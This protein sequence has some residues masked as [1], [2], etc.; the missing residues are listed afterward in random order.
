M[1]RVI[2]LIVGG[3]KWTKSSTL[4]CLILI[5][6]SFNINAESITSDKSMYV[7]SGVVTDANTQEPLAGVNIQIKGE[8][9]GTST[10][11]EGAFSIDVEEDDI[12]IF[13][14]VGFKTVE[15]PVAG[16]TSM[17]VELEEDSQLLDELIVVGYGLQRRESVTGSIASLG[18]DKIEQIPTASFETA[19]QGNVAGVQLISADGAPGANTQI[20]IRGIGS[21]SASSSPLYVV[22]GVIVTSGSLANLNSNGGRS[23]NVMATLNP[24]D[25][26]SVSIL[27]DAAS[28][29][30]YGSRGAN[31]VVLITT[32]SGRS[33]APRVSFKSQLGFNKV[34][35]NSLL[36]PL[37]A[38]EYTTLFLEGYTNRGETSQEAQTRFDNRFEQ[39]TDPQTGLPTDTDWLEE[40]TRTGRNQSYD[41]SVSG[42]SEG[43]RYFVSTN[44]FDQESHIIGTDF[45]RIATRANLD[46]K[47]NNRFDIANKLQLSKTDQ[48]GMVDGSAWANPIYN[49]LL[50]SPLIPIKDE[51][52]LFNSE[53]KNYF[54]MGGNNPVG[55]LS[56]DDLRKIGQFRLN[57][58]LSGR[59]RLLDNLVLDSKVNLD[60]IKVSESS[61]KNPRYGDGRNVGGYAQE[62]EISRESFTGTQTINYIANFDELH[63]IETFIGFEAQKSETKSFTGYGQNFPNLKLT[64]LSSAAE[65]YEASSTLTEFSFASIFAR[66]IYDYDDK[67]FLQ[68][69]IRRDGSSRF[70]S[71]NRWGTFFSVGLGWSLH[72]EEF[73]SD[74]EFIDALKLRSSFGTTGNAEIGN[75]PS[76]GLY[77][78]GRDYDGEPGGV[79]VQIG[80]P[81]LT[82]ERQENFN[83]ALEFGALE[84]I[85]GTIEYFTRNSTDLL[86]DVPISRTTGFADVT[87]NAGSL[88]NKGFE[89]ALNFNIIR[90]QDLTWDIGFNT[91]FI[92]NEVTE[93]NEPYNDGTKRREVGRDYQSYYLYDWAGVD[94]SNGDPLWYTDETRSTTTNDINNAERFFVGKSA[95]PDHYGGFNTA[96]FFKNFSFDAQFSYSWGNYIYGSQ[97]RFIHAD[98]ALTP[99][100]TSKYAFENRWLP[101]KT[102]AE[103]PLHTWG[104][105]NNSNVGNSSRWLHDGSHI[106]LRSLTI[107]YSFPSASI[108]NFGLESLRLY[109]RGLNL[110]TYTRDPD[111]YIDPEQNINGL[112]NSVTPA[113]RSISLGIDVGF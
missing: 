80:N 20:R 45:D 47:V 5:G 63:N 100:S 89:I 40:I 46:V 60:V 113:I 106:R 52:G 59:V 85:T 105:N 49:S 32:K 110:F 8:F 43:V 4:A 61:Y 75:F 96:V 22:D 84:K 12:L 112:A 15:I 103:F 90:K 39:L 17:E 3:L 76:R 74:I 34:A 56:G 11:V 83:L 111:L 87:Q 53:H 70:G 13:S 104:G 93:L 48:N 38:S 16:Q 14:F 50:L 1:D 35:S 91:T 102:D 98:G 10:D 107:A 54:P 44:Y 29:A 37:N 51:A 66:A 64:T 57:N 30:I 2:N 42:G 7:L 31:G 101:G 62:S 36:E 77:G 55:A 68:G 28:T 26:E 78:Y 88:E 82:W 19:L 23:T 27:K 65:A 73:V 97:E 71:D 72:N 86:L 109:T 81:A 58:T 33:G 24:N 108:S 69:S 21:I 41:L 95:T 99:R 25:I 67:Y 94:Q 79:P 18:S 9:R 6:T 92:K